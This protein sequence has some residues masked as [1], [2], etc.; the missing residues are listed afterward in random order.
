MNFR[1]MML[2][3]IEWN[4]FMV[5]MWNVGACVDDVHGQEAIWLSHWVID[6]FDYSEL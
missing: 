2:E 3:N 1:D 4:M 5:E 6:L